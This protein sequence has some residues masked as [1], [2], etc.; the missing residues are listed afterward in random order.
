MNT[1]KA[2]KLRQLVCHLMAK[3]AVAEG[4]WTVYGS[5]K[6]QT[7]KTPTTIDGAAG[8][9]YAITGT[10]MLDPACGKAIYRQMKKRAVSHRPAA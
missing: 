2:K 4:G 1:K 9:P 6:M 3:G 10:V 5:A 7:R 8:Q